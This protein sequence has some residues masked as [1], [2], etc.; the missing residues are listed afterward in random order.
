TLAASRPIAKIL[1]IKILAAPPIN[2]DQDFQR[3]LIVTPRRSGSA[4]QRNKIRRR[5][6]SIFWE[7]EHSAPPPEIPP[8]DFMAIIYKESHSIDFDTLK[9]FLNTAL[10]KTRK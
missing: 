9:A 3:L 7:S 2:P 10:T 5:L 6:K 4:T 1:G 8:R